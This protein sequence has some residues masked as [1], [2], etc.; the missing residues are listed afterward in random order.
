MLN[1]YLNSKPIKIENIT[2][3]TTTSVNPNEFFTYYAKSPTMQKKKWCAK[4]LNASTK[5][6]TNVINLD[7]DKTISISHNNIITLNNAVLNDTNSAFSIS[8]SHCIVTGGKRRRPTRTRRT[9][10]RRPRRTRRTRRPRR[11]ISKK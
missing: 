4:I 8:Q 11:R 1:Q 10:T 3:L 9:R 7:N 5:N 6:N 2:S